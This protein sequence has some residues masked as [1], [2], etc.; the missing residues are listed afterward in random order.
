MQFMCQSFCGNEMR[1]A[2]CI[3]GNPRSNLSVSYF[4]YF[5][6]L[7]Q[8]KPVGAEKLHELSIDCS[9]ESVFGGKI[10][11]CFIAFY[12]L[13]PNFMLYCVLPVTDPI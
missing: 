2:S 9:G 1:N 11:F 7:V 8:K 4:V 6:H 12:V 3:A 13:R 5:K 10:R